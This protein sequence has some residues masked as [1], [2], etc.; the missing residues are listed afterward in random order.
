M[1]PRVPFTTLILIFSATLVL[2]ACRRTAPE[3]ASGGAPAEGQAPSDRGTALQEVTL[4]TTAARLAGIE[5]VTATAVRHGSLVANG[6]ITYDGNHVSIIASRTEGRIVSVRVDLGQAVRKGDVLA[7]IESPE[8]G[9]TRGL[10]AR[11]RSSVDIT[12][13]NYEREKR[14]YDESISSQKEML[15]A[16]GEYWNAQADL[17]ASMAKLRAL[18]AAPEGEGGTFGLASPIDGTVVDRHATPGQIVGPAIDLLTVADLRHVWITVDVYEADVGRIRNGAR[19][20]VMPAASADSFPGRVT[21][22]GAVVDSL[23]RTVKVRVEVENEARQLRPG[24]FARVAIATPA[25]APK[26]SAAGDP[27]LLPDIAVQDL[28]GRAVVFVPGETP[29]QFV[30]RPVTVDLAAPPGM[31]VVQRGVRPGERVVAK[32]AFQLKAE[33]TK[34]RFG[35]DD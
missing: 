7:L 35:E 2:S 25:P 18:G 20:R 15:Q 14:L 22:A 24:M 13:R 23:T 17:T 3:G 27:V 26:D 21:F 29:G 11:A 12:R 6:T 28:D 31:V 32:G 10:W 33:L 16:E 19:A 1:N 5:L 4:D 9:E 30:V 8:V 34:A